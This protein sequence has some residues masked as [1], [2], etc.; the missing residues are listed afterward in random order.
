MTELQDQE[1]L[2][3]VQK[4]QR[5]SL[6]TLLY[7]CTP[8][9]L[10]WGTAGLQTPETLAIS[11]LEGK[12]TVDSFLWMEREELSFKTILLQES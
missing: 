3:G 5:E 2:R 12:G 8:T 1:K 10:G 6:G 4:G 11:Q 9:T 7:T